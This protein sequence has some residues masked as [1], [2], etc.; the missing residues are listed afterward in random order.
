MTTKPTTT[1]TERH[2]SLADE[3]GVKRILIETLG[4]LWAAQSRL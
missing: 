3:A 2:V 4:S 1:D